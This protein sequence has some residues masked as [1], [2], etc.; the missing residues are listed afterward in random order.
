MRPRN[1]E[2]QIMHKGPNWVLRVYEDR[3]GKRVRVAKLLCRYAE[4]PLRGTATD[5]EFLRKKYAE[6]I[7][8]FLAPVNRDHVTATGTITLGEFVEQQYWVRC[9]QRLAIPAGNE[10]HM[11]RSTI[12]GYHDIYRKHIESSAIAKSKIQNIT[13]SIAQNFIEG[14][15]QTLSHQTHMRI[16][17][18]LSGVFSWAIV[19]GA[20]RGNNPMGEVKAGGRKKGGPILTGLSESEKLRKQKIAESNNHAYTLEEVADMI[21]KLPEPARTVCALSAFTGLSRSELWGL[22]W[23]DYNGEYIQVKRKIVDNV[24]GAPKTEA[25]EDGVYIVPLLR[26][27]LTA[28]KK[29]L[30]V[31][32]DGGWMFCGEK[33]GP[34]NLDN[35]SRRDIP[36]HINGAWFGWHAFRRGL[37][38]RLNEAGVDDKTI[39]SILRHADVSTTMAYYVKPDRAAGERGLRKL[40]TVMQQKYKIKV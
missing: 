28:Y 23:E 17:N 10:L 30:K 29:G 40:S 36:V 14:L 21:N 27:M 38:T 39:Q 35:V 1:Q 2:G 25:R 19:K 4:H 26:K 24:E 33:G 8:Q 9:E 13:P 20:Y 5:L 22:K 31:A 11:E 34:L 3:D 7:A 37:G 15:D 18:F 6:Q 16:K 32:C 12:D